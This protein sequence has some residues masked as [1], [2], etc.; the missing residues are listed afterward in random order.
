MNLTKIKENFCK[1]MIK[2]LMAKQQTLTIIY[3]TNIHGLE[4]I[5]INNH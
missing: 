4:V 1:T 2:Q 3:Y 5:F